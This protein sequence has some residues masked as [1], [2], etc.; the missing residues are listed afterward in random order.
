LKTLLLPGNLGDVLF[1]RRR[2]SSGL[3]SKGNLCCDGRPPRRVQVSRRR[4]V[5]GDVHEQVLRVAVGLRLRLLETSES[6]VRSHI[7]S[8][9]SHKM[10][11]QVLRVAPWPLRC[12]GLR[13]ACLARR[14]DQK[15][16]NSG[17]HP[18][19]GR[20]AAFYS[21]TVKM[22]TQRNGQSSEETRA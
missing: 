13:Y 12:A 21:H 6:L 22:C 8:F 14:T 10:D 5:V 7:S 2:S 20:A 9:F 16:L 3:A 18:L 19:T 4:P 11:E 17:C 15:K 1:I